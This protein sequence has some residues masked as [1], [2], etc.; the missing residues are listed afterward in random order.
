MF[1]VATMLERGESDRA[2]GIR[3]GGDQ[4]NP[5]SRCCVYKRRPVALADQT[6]SRR[7]GSNVFL[8]LQGLG[9]G[10][11]VCNDVLGVFWAALRYGRFL[12]P[13]ATDWT[14]F[15]IFC[16]HRNAVYCPLQCTDCIL[17]FSLTGSY[18]PAMRSADLLCCR[19]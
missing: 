12:D 5:S 4:C 19:F 10:L 14:H 13:P 1:H 15:A 18:C 7:F 9:K 16:F 2:L 17:C 6:I 3:R 8:Q 11:L